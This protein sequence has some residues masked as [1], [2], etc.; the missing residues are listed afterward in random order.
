MMFPRWQLRCSKHLYHLSNPDD[1]KQRAEIFSLEQA[2]EEYMKVMG[3]EASQTI[4][5]VR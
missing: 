3:V 5:S 2:V 1:L 4:E